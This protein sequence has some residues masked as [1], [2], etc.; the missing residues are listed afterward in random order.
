MLAR[1]VFWGDV[2]EGGESFYAK[3]GMYGREFLIRETSSVVFFL[4]FF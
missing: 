4:F 2:R 3:G 1:G